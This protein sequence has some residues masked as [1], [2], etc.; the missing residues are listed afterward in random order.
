MIY[1]NQFDPND[2]DPE[3]TVG[4]Y[5]QHYP[6]G[7]STQ[8]EFDPNLGHHRDFL[9]VG[10]YIFV[11]KTDDDGDSRLLVSY[12]RQSFKYQHHTT[13]KST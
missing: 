2:Q 4:L 13:I 1:F 12:N 11:Q 6:Y 7:P 3:Y 10:P 5:T 8:E 9:L